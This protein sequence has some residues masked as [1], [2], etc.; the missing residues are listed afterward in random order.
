MGKC[1]LKHFGFYTV[2][3]PKNYQLQSY[4]IVD[5]RDNTVKRFERIFL[6]NKTERGKIFNNKRSKSMGNLWYKGLRYGCRCFLK[7]LF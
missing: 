1:A 3:T 2:Y 6:T 7:S 4:R 5:V